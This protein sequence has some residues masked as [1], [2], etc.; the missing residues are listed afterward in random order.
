MFTIVFLARLTKHLLIFL[1]TTLPL[2]LQGV[3]LLLPVML[4]KDIGKLPRC[5]RWFDSADPFVGRDTSV[6][7]SINNGT[8]TYYPHVRL[9]SNSFLRTLVLAWDKYRWLA[10][11]NPINY[12]QYSV[13]GFRAYIMGEEA[14]IIK[15][16]DPKD[17]G[18]S[19][20]DHAVD[21]PGY[22]YIEQRINNSLYYEYY[23]IIPIKYPFLKKRVLRFRLGYKLSN[24]NPGDW[25]QEVLTVNPIHPVDYIKSTYWD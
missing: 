10:W 24:T 4:V 9:P 5:L 8:S 2:Q 13:L 1:L 3:I 16:L 22:M 20:G 14:H 23:A 7:K 18:K 11:R 17:V 15:Y 19:I 25:V 6:I 12:F 21:A